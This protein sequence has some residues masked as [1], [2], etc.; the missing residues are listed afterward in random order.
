MT[1]AGNSL[2]ARLTSLT[3][4]TKYI[5]RVIAINELGAGDPSKTVTVY[6]LEEGILTYLST[7]LMVRFDN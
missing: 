3:P 1:V 6:T 4:S 2:A 5:V 7:W